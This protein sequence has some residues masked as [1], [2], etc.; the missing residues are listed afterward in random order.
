ML[1]RLPLLRLLLGPPHLRIDVG[2]LFLQA[3]EIVPGVAEL[4]LR[5]GGRA[6]IGGVERG[7]ELSL[8]IQGV[9]LG[10]LERRIDG[11][12]SRAPH[13]LLGVLSPLGGLLSHRLGLGGRLALRVQLGAEFRRRHRRRTC[14]PCSPS[15]RPR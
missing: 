1:L 4:L 2:A 7:L 6:V 15:P 12:E 5:L 10:G 9:L 8:E 3:Q 13:L 11:V 14:R